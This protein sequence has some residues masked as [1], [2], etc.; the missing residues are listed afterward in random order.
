MWSDHIP[1]LTLDSKPTSRVSHLRFPLPAILLTSG[2]LL[3]LMAPPCQ[4]QT[5][6]RG[7]K[8][9]SQSPEAAG[10]VTQTR[11]QGAPDEVTE[12]LAR[13][14]NSLSE[15]S[16]V[17]S[18]E[19]PDIFLLPPSVESVEEVSDPRAGFRVQLGSTRQI[20]LA[21][22]LQEEFTAW[23]DSVFPGYR[24]SAY[25]LFKQPYYKVHIGDFRDRETAT[26]LARALK[27]K[28]PEAWVVY[29]RIE[30]AR[31][32]SEGVNVLPAADDRNAAGSVPPQTTSPS[33]TQGMRT[34]R[35][36]GG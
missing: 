16:E 8:N 32:P 34:E 5:W 26:L 4:A 17:R 6:G 28:Y 18:A 13:T 7:S 11:S 3:S 24:P 14:R 35:P 33:D 2:I 27:R 15:L 1:A 12:L 19:Y 30:P 22:S 36:D 9:T 23:S 31:V 21:D 20:A 29:D 10:D 25:L